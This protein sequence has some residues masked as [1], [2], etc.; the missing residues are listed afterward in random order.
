MNM[1]WGALLY[2]ALLSVV[3][4]L[5]RTWAKDRQRKDSHNISESNNLNLMKQLSATLIT[6]LMSKKKRIQ[7]ESLSSVSV[8]LQRVIK[9][10]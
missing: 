10:F 5:E 7:K 1:L 9:K 8:S 6:L 4:N 3:E 2:C